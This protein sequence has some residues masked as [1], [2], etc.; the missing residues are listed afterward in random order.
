MIVFVSL[1]T[2]FKVG[3]ILDC[4]VSILNLFRP[5]TRPASMAKLAM[6]KALIYVVWCR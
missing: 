2:N 1:S 3:S 4:L 5:N 6:S